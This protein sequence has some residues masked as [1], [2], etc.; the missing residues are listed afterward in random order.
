MIRFLTSRL[1][2]LVHVAGLKNL[3]P[4]LILPTYA[5]RSAG[6]LSSRSRMTIKAAEEIWS[7]LSSFNAKLRDQEIRNMEELK[8]QGDPQKQ[9]Q[10]DALFERHGSDK[11]ST[12]NYGRLYSWLADEIHV[13]VLCEIGIGSKSAA[14][15]R[16]P[17][18]AI[19]GGSLRAFRDFF[20]LAHVVGA[21]IDPD[22][23][24]QDE[25]IQCFFLDQLEPSTFADLKLHLQS[26]GGAQVIIDDGLHSP[27]S[28]VWSLAELWT[29]LDNDGFWIIEDLDRAHLSIY[30]LVA[31]LLPPTSRVWFWEEGHSIALVIRK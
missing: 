21:D 11:S 7:A 19:P 3:F 10:I 20:P 4:T 14:L 6:S 9:V 17:R 12:H 27:L 16:M 1:R 26:L 8:P 31:G 2:R 15:S 23:L 30:G 24:F 28:A 25:R 29:L 13:K 22:V 18:S 5:P